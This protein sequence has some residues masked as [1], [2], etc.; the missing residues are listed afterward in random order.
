MRTLD[1]NNNMSALAPDYCIDNCPEFELPNIFSPNNDDANDFFKAIKVKQIKEID[2][3]VVDRWGHVVY[4]TTDPY[5]KWNGVSSASNVAVSEG[6]FFFVCDVYESRLVGIVKR[7]IK[8]T[9][10]VVR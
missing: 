4:K 3:A 8:G 9:V 7:T 5:F 6:T 2:L 10:Q 1:T